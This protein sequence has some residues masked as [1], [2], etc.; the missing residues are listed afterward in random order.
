LEYKR[1]LAR[2]YRPRNLV[3]T[4]VDSTVL[5]SLT[6][7]VTEVAGNTTLATTNT[8][9]NG[10]VGIRHDINTMTSTAHGLPEVIALALSILVAI[11]H[12]LQECFTAYKWYNTKDI[13]HHYSGWFSI[14]ASLGCVLVAFAVAI[15]IWVDYVRLRSHMEVKEW[16]QLDVSSPPSFSQI[17]PLSLLSTSV[18]PV[19]KAF[20][21]KSS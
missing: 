21:G 2:V 11:G 9:G 6:D 13:R 10:V 3:L 14:V 18:F 1:R 15:Y 8:T 5:T 19:F 20:F 16:Y 12:L 17:F 7:F 4:V